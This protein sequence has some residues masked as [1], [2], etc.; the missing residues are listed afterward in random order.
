VSIRLDVSLAQEQLSESLIFADDRILSFKLYHTA[1]LGEDIEI[2][3]LWPGQRALLASPG[4]QP[5]PRCPD[6]G[7]AEKLISYINEDTR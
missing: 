2:N 4:Q 1:V 5:P 6:P 7:E 3:I